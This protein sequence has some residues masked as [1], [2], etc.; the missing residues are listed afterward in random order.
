ME[1][2]VGV[3][4]ANVARREKNKRKRKKARRS[5]QN[6]NFQHDLQYQDASTA[7]SPPYHHPPGCDI[8][9]YFYPK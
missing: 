1:D 9:K 2:N 4:E 6:E 7:P 8:I 5:F 3:R